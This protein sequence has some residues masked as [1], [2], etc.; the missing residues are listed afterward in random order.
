MVSK[1]DAE[2][3]ITSDKGR[4]IKRELYFFYGARTEDDLLYQEE[5]FKISR[6]HP[7]FHYYPVLS[8]GTESWTGATGYVQDLLS[9]SINQISQIKGVEFYLCGPPDMMSTTIDLLKT[10][11]ID[12]S[13][14]AF[15]KFTQYPIKILLT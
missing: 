8:R 13:N 3:L 1:N 6:L 9:L 5:L 15:D 11:N 7:Q 12:E 10:K 14:I 2:Q 4:L